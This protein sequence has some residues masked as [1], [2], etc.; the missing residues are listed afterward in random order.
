MKSDAQLQQDVI[1]ELKWQPAI[2]AAQIG[3]EAKNGVVTLSGHVSSYGEKWQAERA[4]KRVSGVNTLAVEI[5]VALPR[6]SKRNDTD[7]AAAARSAVKWTTWLLDQ[8]IDVM[9]EDG[10]IT[11]SGEVAWDFQRQSAAHAVRQIAGV[12]GVSDDITIK[13]HASASIVKSDIEAALK[14]RA[15]SD[16]QNIRVDVR[17]ADV[18]LS[19]TVHSW[20]ERDLARE[21]AWAA[22]GVHNVVD[23]MTV[24]V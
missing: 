13:S 12:T 7:I 9:V 15:V 14:R 5:D 18:T 4:A 3:V 1:A 20:S 16:A 17:G 24:A 6:S 19:G 11:L 10:W 8:R 21:S 23:E 22:P 2:N